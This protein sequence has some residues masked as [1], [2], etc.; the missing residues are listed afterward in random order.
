MPLALIMSSHVAASRVGAGV[1]A[2]ALAHFRIEQ[3]VVPTVLFGRHPG[4]G[5]PGGAAVPL[6]TFE[7]VLDG[8]E[9]NGLFA[10]TDLVITG[11]FASAAQVRAAGRAIDAVRGAPR[12]ED[13]KRPVVIVDPVMGDVGKGLYVAAEVA[14]T[15]VSDLLPRADVITPN[16]W[17]LDRLTHMQVRDPAS[18]VAAAKV[19][20]RP[21]LCT[22]VMRGNEIGAV[23]ADRNEAWFAAHVNTG[24]APRGSGDLL[25]AL[26]GAA[27]LEGVPPSHALARAVGGVVETISV[28]HTWETPELSVIGMGAKIKTASPSVRLERLA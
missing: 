1:Q 19:L 28:A 20:G 4:W 25:T 23:Y 3:M 12:P 6:E 9:A 2:Q 7:G 18:A 24:P 11:Y 5:E 8:I 13:A 26:F 10:E 21:V 22:S 27:M 14:Q 16:T 15:I 17:E